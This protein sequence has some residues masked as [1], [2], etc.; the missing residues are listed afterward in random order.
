M[1]QK[2]LFFV[3]VVL[4]LFFG[5]GANASAAGS[6][7]GT[8]EDMFKNQQNMQHPASK[9]KNAGNSNAASDSQ[10]GS[11]MTGTPD[12]FVTFLKLV[13]ALLL[14]L[15]LIYL[16]YHFVAKRTG[17]FHEGSALKNIGGVSVGANR[18][19]QLIHLG[20]EVLVVGVGETVQLLKEI[21]DP[22][23]IESLVN[24]EGKPDFIEGNVRKIVNWTAEKTLKKRSVQNKGGS[25]SLKPL[26]KES[27]DRLK[28]ERS[29]RMEE[30]FQ[31]EEK[32]E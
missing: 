2:R 15:G 20:D 3:I 30:I 24:Q 28:K 7:N 8:V 31:G 23:T 22:N 1:F 29:D 17:R 16:L 6:G 14:V 26:L 10:A 19:V 18:S 12:L 27:L 4:A 9:T 5:Q 11:S 32:H 25:K 13:F 21:T